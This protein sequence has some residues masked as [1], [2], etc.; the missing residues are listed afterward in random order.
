MVACTKLQNYERIF[1]YSHKPSAFA[2]THGIADG[3]NGNKRLIAMASSL[4]SKEE[5][6]NGKT[7]ATA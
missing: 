5:K 3:K 2:L 4:F 6:L 1:L 7:Y